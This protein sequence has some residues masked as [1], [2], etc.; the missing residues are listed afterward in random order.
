MKVLRDVER[1]EEIHRVCDL[2]QSGRIGEQ[3]RFAGEPAALPRGMDL[4]D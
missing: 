3:G 4:V 1:I 2:H